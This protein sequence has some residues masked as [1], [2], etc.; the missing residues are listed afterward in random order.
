MYLIFSEWIYEFILVPKTDWELP[1][2]GRTEGS[3]IFGVRCVFPG[4]LFCDLVSRH[5]KSERDG[6]GLDEFGEIVRAETAIKVDRSAASFMNEM[7]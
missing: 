5:L 3:R 4:R 6:L 7:D 2:G 1:R